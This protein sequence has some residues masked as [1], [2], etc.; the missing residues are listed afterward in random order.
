M[1]VTLELPAVTDAES[2]EQ[3]EKRIW[4]AVALYDARLVSQGV[5][6]ELAGLTRTAFIDALSRAGVSVLQYTAEEAIAE[7]RRK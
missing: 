2:D 3:R 1:T 7:A 5:A 6:A 4:A